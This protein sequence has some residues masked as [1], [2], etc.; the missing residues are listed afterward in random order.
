MTC[1]PRALE[2]VQN[3]GFDYH[4]QH[5]VFRP[6]RTAKWVNVTRL[7]YG[8]PNHALTS[9][10]S[11]FGKI[12]HVKMDIYQGVYVGVRNILMEITNPIPSSLQIAGH[13]CNIFYLGQT[14]TCFAC[15]Q[16]GHTRANCPRA[17]LTVPAVDAVEEETPTLHSPA[18]RNL[19]DEVLGSVVDHVVAGTVNDQDDVAR[20]TTMKIF[21]TSARRLFP[22]QWLLILQWMGHRV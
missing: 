3:L 15:R 22:P 5:V 19:A 18:R 7:S 9:A 4:G 20:T 11:P 10:L 1:T 13:W 12:L 21:L 2:E 17:D 6:C 16:L 14:P 8:I